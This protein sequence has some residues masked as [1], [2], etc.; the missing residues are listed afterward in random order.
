MYYI[1][2]DS[3]LIFSRISP[4][5]MIVGRN[6]IDGVLYGRKGELFTCS[7][8][9]FESDFTIIDCEPPKFTGLNKAEKT[10]S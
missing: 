10:G 1:K 8:A 3:F 7:K 9:A 4:V 6:S 5:K 2:K